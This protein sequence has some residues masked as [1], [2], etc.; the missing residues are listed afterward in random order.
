MGVID[1]DYSR[2]D[3]LPEFSKIILKDR[4][5]LPGEKSPQDMFARVCKAVSSDSAHAQRLYDYVSKLW[6]MFSSP[7]LSNAGTS[8]GL[9]ISCFLSD[10]EDSTESISANIEESIYLS[11]NGG[12]LGINFSKIR[13]LGSPIRNGEAESPGVVPHIKVAEALTAA[14]QQ[15]S[16]R[17]GSTAAYLDISHP[18][19]EEFIDIRR[20]T[21]DSNRR[22]LSVG[23]HHAVNIPDRFMDS[24]E[25]GTDWELIDPHTQ[26][27]VK[28][29]D[30]RALW[31]KILK[32]RVETGEPYLHFIDTSNKHLPQKLKEK[33]LRINHTN[34]C[35]E[36]YLPT[37]A[38]RT[39]VCCLSS[40][41]LEKYEE[42]RNDPLFIEDVIRMLDNVLSH[43]ISHAPPK[44]H[45]A[46]RSAF[47]E[48][49]IGLGAMG[50]HSFLQ[51]KGV[52]F[53][54]PVARSWN[55]A[56]FLKIKEE[57]VKA[58]RKIG[59]ERGSP[60]DLEGTGLRFAH[61]LA[62]APNASSADICGVTSPSIEPWSTNAFK[63]KG[64]SGTFLIKNKYLH[65]LLKEKGQDTEA[66][67]AS[68]I[69]NEGS[70]QHL[71][72][73][74]EHERMVFK[75]AFELDQRWIIE[76]AADRQQYVCQGQSVN[77]FFLPNTNFSYLHKV[78]KEAW[79]KGLKGL[80]YCRSI[81]EG[82]GDKLTQTITESDCLSCEG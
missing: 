37:S 13:G 75:T 33:G 10:I 78:H 41:N 5:M 34:L 68:I 53:E 62:I 47:K 15:G 8:R 51:S 12:G 45:R 54:S 82:R 39:A 57:A 23:F 21:G 25:K 32:A 30:A 66:V 59:K 1:V 20:P 4:Y 22:C 48:R 9:L 79:S 17:R 63:K 69:N 65:N 19:I 35:S 81:S 58:S 42:W 3:L 7:I 52:A 73:L 64:L 70:V 24:L 11:K 56:I 6:F 31:Q 50:F 28:K 60:P 49:S 40:V 76:H 18:E 72:F 74:N 26:E 71:S 27:I 67:W 36:I 46:I 55:N 43:F 61:L 44:L 2:D 29:V 38:D 14:W 77:L 16:N 80:Y